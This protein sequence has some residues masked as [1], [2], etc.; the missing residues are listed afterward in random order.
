MALHEIYVNETINR[1][2]QYNSKSAE[3]KY[4]NVA[5][6]M[7]FKRRVWDVHHPNIP[8]PASW[9][10]SDSGQGSI[11]DDIVVDQEIQSLKCPITLMLLEKPVRNSTCPHVYSLDAIK[12]LARHS[13]GECECPVAG[14]PAI[15]RMEQLREDKVMARKVR[16]E[17]SREDERAA[18]RITES[19]VLTDEESEIVLEDMI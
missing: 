18:N 7:D 8:Q 11:D 3:E 13:Y 9:F 10:A 2:K 14:C 4:A 19:H 6:F 12:E 15:V 1:D 16:E 17:K 5:E